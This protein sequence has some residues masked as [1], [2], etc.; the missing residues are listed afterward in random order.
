MSCSISIGNIMNGQNVPLPFEVSGSV[1][2]QSTGATDS[3][4]AVAMQIDDNPLLDLTV[5]GSP[6]LR[7]FSVELTSRDCPTMNTYYML[8][9]YAWDN[10]SPS[11]SMA[12]VTFKTVDLFAPPPVPTQPGPNPIPSPLPQPVPFPGG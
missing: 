6:T 5:G 1:M 12:S 9:I 11:A 8:T 3:I 4:T 2:L 10:V 7:T